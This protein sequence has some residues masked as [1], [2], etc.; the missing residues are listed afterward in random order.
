MISRYEEAKEKEELRG[1]LLNSVISAQ[2]EERRR[3]ARELHDE[4][5]QTLTGLI[6][7]IESLE[8]MTTPEQSQLK[9]KL[10]D[11]KSL[12][13][14]TL[15]SIRKLTLD[16]YPSSLD[17][18]GLVAAIR[19]YIANHLQTGGISVKFDSQ[20]L[21]QRPVPPVETAQVCL[22]KWALCSLQASLADR[23]GLGLPLTQNPD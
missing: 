8:N 9:R 16:L 10:A 12:I 3:I 18:L 4:Y 7:S 21:S 20:G 1:E 15:D 2:E 23:L 11:T 19:T 22:C 6:M 5:G 17:D 14:S 13:V